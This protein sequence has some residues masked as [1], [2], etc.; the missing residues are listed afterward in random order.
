MAKRKEALQQSELF[1]SLDDEV[2]DQ[3]ASAAEM[4]ERSE[5]EI[6]FVELE[7]NEDIYFLIDGTVRLEV[8]IAGEEH[9]KEIATLESGV[10]FGLNSFIELGPRLTTAVATSPVK[11]LKWKAG[12]WRAICNDRPDVGYHL[13]RYIARTLVVAFMKERLSLLDHMEWGLE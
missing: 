13:C 8:K 3:F 10:P 7:E 6:I 9:A 12:D 11:L 4:Q 5:G 1:A 2:I